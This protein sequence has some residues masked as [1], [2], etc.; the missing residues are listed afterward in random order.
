MQHKE[1]GRSQANVEKNKE[2]R[3]F[4]F[5]TRYRDFSYAWYKIILSGLTTPDSLC[6]TS[7]AI[8]ATNQRFENALS[9]CSLNQ[10]STAS[11]RFAKEFPTRSL[12]PGR[13]TVF[14]IEA[15]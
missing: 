6:M 3:F 4:R 15:A 5:Y 13:A 9:A 11:A 1:K 7:F 12:I 2:D 8:R 10:C 14:A